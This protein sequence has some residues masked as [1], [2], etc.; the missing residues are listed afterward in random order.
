MSNSKEERAVFSFS[1]TNASQLHLGLQ[2][3]WPLRRLKKKTLTGLVIIVCRVVS[4]GVEISI[5]IMLIK[6]ELVLVLHNVDRSRGGHLLLTH[7][8]GSFISII[9]HLAEI[10]LSIS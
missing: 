2:T 3:R 5:H 4:I 10:A 7:V 1:Y 9:N 6:R 8:Y